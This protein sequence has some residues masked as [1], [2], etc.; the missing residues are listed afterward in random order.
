MELQPPNEILS[1]FGVRLIE[2][3][4]GRLNRHWLV[5]TWSERLVLRSWWQSADEID[6]ELRL[7]GQLAARGWPVAPT[8]A[9]PIESDGAAWSLAPFLPGEPRADKNSIAEQRSRGRL[10]AELHADLAQLTNLGQRGQW[11]R[12]EEVVLHRE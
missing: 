8:V 5:E 10:L 12:C 1:Q 4:G 7:V 6:Y 9:G 3:L 11:R 2:P